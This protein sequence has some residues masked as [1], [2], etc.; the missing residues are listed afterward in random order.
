VVKPKTEKETEE[1]VKKLFQPPHLEHAPLKE[2]L[3]KLE[4]PIE[5]H[6]GSIV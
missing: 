6:L 3:F 1:L 2:Y 5:I 4:E